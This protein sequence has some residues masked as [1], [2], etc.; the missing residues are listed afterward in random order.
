MKK[1]FA[2]L[3]ALIIILGF[4]FYTQ[5]TLFIVPPIGAVPEG[6]IVVILRHEQTNFIDSPDAI[7]QRIQGKVNLLCRGLVIVK[8]LENSKII[9]RLPYNETLYSISTN[10]KLYY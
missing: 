8:V 6:K 7:C 10:G 2:I 1:G 4:V 5:F 3:F 9:M